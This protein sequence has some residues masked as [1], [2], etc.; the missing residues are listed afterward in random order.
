MGVIGNPFKLFGRI[1]V[2]GFLIA[3]YT[4]TFIIQILWYVFHRQTNKIIDAY[5][6]FWKNILDIIVGV[7]RN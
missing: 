4:A 7:F 6:V 1:L 2:A 3:E 5:A